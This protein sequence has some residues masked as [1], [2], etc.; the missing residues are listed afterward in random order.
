MGSFPV[1]LISGT[2][3]LWLVAVLLLAYR[4]RIDGFHPG[5]K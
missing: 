4:T 3:L 5:R 2:L 1:L